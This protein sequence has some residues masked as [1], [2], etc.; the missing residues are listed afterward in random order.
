MNVNA[1]SY[2][3]LLNIARLGVPP[4]GPTAKVWDGGTNAGKRILEMRVEIPV[5]A[6]DKSAIRAEVFAGLKEK[7]DSRIDGR[8]RALANSPTDSAAYNLVLGSL[9][10]TFITIE[11]AQRAID[12]AWSKGEVYGLE[13][14]RKYVI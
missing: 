2:Y 1:Y 4:T 11:D 6:P 10:G 14:A 13:S 12:Y 8:N 9:K 3:E 5:T 7:I